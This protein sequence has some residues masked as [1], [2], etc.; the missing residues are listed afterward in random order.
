MKVDFEKK[1]KDII[2]LRKEKHLQ[3][4][5]NIINNSAFLVEKSRFEKEYIFL[6]K[7]LSLL[8]TL[9][10]EEQFKLYREILIYINSSI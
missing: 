8:K 6:N 3:K 1:I 2:T 10:V 7:K 4:I 5:G 9:N